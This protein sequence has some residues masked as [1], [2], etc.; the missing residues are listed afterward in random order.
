MSK[1]DGCETWET[2]GITFTE[3]IKQP[4]QNCVF[5]AGTTSHKIDTVYIRWER[6]DGTG[7]MLMLR[8]DELAAIGWIS[9]GV[10]WSILVK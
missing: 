10:L 4:Y 5:A 6:D 1:S 9:T 3:L 2:D 7:G 8:P